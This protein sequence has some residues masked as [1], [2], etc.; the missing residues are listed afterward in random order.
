MIIPVPITWFFRKNIKDNYI[1]NKD[2]IITY[3]QANQKGGQNKQLLLLTIDTA[4]KVSMNTGSKGR[5]VSN[6]FIEIN[7]AFIRYKDLTYE[8][9]LKENEKLKLN[10][11]PIKLNNR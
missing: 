1:E 11:N 4:L 3:P 5:E 9:L 2:Y 6:Y 8:K 7:K 10:M